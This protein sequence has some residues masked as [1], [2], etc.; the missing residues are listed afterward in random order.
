MNILLDII[1]PTPIEEFF[2]NLG[3]YTVNARIA[4]FAA[5]FAVAA[6]AVVL[7]VKAIKKKK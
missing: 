1:P 7:I 6:T 2:W 5:V 3:I 4:V